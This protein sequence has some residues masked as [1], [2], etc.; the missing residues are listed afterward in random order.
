MMNSDDTLKG[1]EL[2]TLLDRLAVEIDGDNNGQELAALIHSLTTEKSRYK[3]E[4]I[5]QKIGSVRLEKTAEA[6]SN[7]LYSED[8]YIRNLAIELLVIL[9]DK[10]LPSL[11]IK[12]GDR[13]RNIRKFSLDALKYIRGKESC[14][15]AVTALDDSDENVVEAALEV[16]AEQAYKEA[17]GKLR[18]MLNNTSSVWVMNALIRTY[19]SLGIKEVSE[20]IAEK[21]ISEN[22]TAIEKNIL[23]N[24]YIRALGAIGTYSD[25]GLILND[26]SKNYNISD[27]NMV[28]GLCS[29]IVNNNIFSLPDVEL[30][31]FKRFFRDQW[32]YRDSENI[33]I[34]I[35][36]FA[37]LQMDFFLHYIIEIYELNKGEEFFIEN[38]SE[39]LY[40]LDHIPPSTIK[41]LL[42]CQESQLILLGLRLIYKK[43][44]EGFNSIVEKLCSSQDREISG[45]AISIVAEIT[46]YSNPHLLESL[47]SIS[48][49]AEIA[50]V[51]SKCTDGIQNIDFLLDK[52][53]HP[54]I[55]V[56]KAAVKKLDLYNGKISV[57]QLEG[58]VWRNPGEEGLEALEVLFK[59]NRNI[60]WKHINNR[61]DSI[62][63]EVRA[64]LINIVEHSSED[65]FFSFMNTMINDPSP[66]VRKKAIKALSKRPDDRSLNL[67]KNLYNN[68]TNA[69]NRMDIISNLY[70]FQ[71]V[72]AFN[73]A[74]SAAHSHETLTRIAAVRTLGLFGGTRADE[75]LQKLLEDQVEEVREA[76]KEALQNTEVKKCY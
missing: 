72:T 46:S 74:L 75:V 57:D 62:N 70:K 15:I 36:A 6:V 71:N 19:E 56:R 40:R 4:K 13:D 65:E 29:L 31:E 18:N 49:E 44:I 38:F 51:E 22:F 7:L 67:L 50:S 47:T 68:E 20:V 42:E 26:Y 10:A 41:E 34:A 59:L 11:K 37:N 14:E 63:E 8:A 52:L 27:E 3:Q 39:L 54:N 16:I 25:I 35:N 43:E 33:L 28:F 1:E 55:K 5:A 66:V 69:V 53:E 45:Q 32:D 9:G 58:I 73:L 64:G 23:M 60:G 2:T 21:I 61:L 30:T 76:A 24:T 12:L 17:E 48:D